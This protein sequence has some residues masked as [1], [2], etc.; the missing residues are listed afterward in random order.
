MRGTTRRKRVCR[1][2]KKDFYTVEINEASAAYVEE[3]K[4]KLKRATH[5]I[6]LRLFQLQEAVST[7]KE[8]T[9]DSS[10]QHA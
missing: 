8:L 7:L 2:C 1:L 3:G 9:G 10:N 6:T 5:A 4:P